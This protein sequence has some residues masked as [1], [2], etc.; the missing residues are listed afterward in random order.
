[1]GS[2]DQVLQY[3]VRDAR[4]GQRQSDHDTIRVFL[5]GP[6]RIE[7]RNG[8]RIVGRHS[9]FLLGPLRRFTF[10]RFCAARKRSHRSWERAFSLRTRND[11][12]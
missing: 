10:R 3:V 5:D 9:R 2:A 6:R 7:C 12:R 8:L 1:M 4:P 11:N